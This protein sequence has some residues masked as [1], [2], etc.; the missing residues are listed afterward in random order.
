MAVLEKA[1]ELIVNDIKKDLNDEYYKEYEIESWSEYLDATGQ[2]SKTLKEN[3]VYILNNEDI[4]LNDSYELENGFELV[5]FRKLMSLV[6][7][8]LKSEGYLK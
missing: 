1:I 3:V 6:R 8:Q 4:Y 7:K 2:D 5:S